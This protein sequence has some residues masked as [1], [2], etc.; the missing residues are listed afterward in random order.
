MNVEESNINSARERNVVEPLTS[1]LKNLLFNCG[2]MQERVF[3]NG[4]QIF[5][6]FGAE[7]YLVRRFV[8]DVFG[9]IWKVINSMRHS[10]TKISRKEKCEFSSQGHFKRYTNCFRIF[11]SARTWY[12]CNRFISNLDCEG[13]WCCPYLRRNQFLCGRKSQ[14]SNCSLYI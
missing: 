4:G 7:N 14:S 1:W 11:F 13:L 12:L 3:S 9:K 2:L 10:V 5:R 8:V 6:D